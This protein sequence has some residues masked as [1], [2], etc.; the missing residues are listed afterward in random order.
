[1]LMSDVTIVISLIRFRSKAFM[2]AGCSSARNARAAH[3]ALNRPV[4]DTKS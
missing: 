1:M 4:M 2:S 3:S